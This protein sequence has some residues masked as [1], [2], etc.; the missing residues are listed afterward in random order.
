MSP[1]RSETAP[2]Q[3]RERVDRA[4]LRLLERAPTA[5]LKELLT[6]TL[7]LAEELTG[8]QIGFFH[9]VEEDQGTLCLQAWSTNTVARMCGAEGAGSHYPIDRAGIWADCVRTGRPVVHND[10]ASAPGKKGMPPGHAAVVRELT[11][12]VVRHGRVCA[13]LGVGNKP[14]D[15]DE[16]DVADVS[17]LADLAW[18]IAARKRAEEA[19]AAS[20]ARYRALFE[21]MRDGLV[22]VGMD[23]VIRDFNEVYRK[24]L[25][26][27]ADELRTKTY[28]ELTPERWHAAEAKVVSEQVLP[29]GFS[30]VYEKE[31]RRRDGTVFPVELRT[32]LMQEEGRPSAMWAIVRDVTE[33]KQSRARIAAPERPGPARTGSPVGAAREHRRRGLVRRP[34]AAVRAGQP[35]RAL[36]VRDAGPGRRLRRGDGPIP[37][38]PPGRWLPAPGGGGASP[39]RAA[40]RGR[41]RRGGAGPH[42]RGRRASHPPGERLAGAGSRRRRSSARSRWCGT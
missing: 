15:Y 8:S 24:M 5:T 12:P 20:E 27:P 10:Y 41:G 9:F 34:G 6:A 38:G 11:V 3:R 13:A 16:A 22:V 32:I 7:D 40:R 2:A 21:T 23:G 36:P 31:Y 14:S 35:R 25:G 4:R 17:T 28:P 29:R 33:R 30:E 42:P 1:T 37:G 19:L 26:Y 39:P 18:D